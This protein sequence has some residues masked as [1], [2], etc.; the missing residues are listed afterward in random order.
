MTL[1]G[2]LL[3]VGIAA[4]VGTAQLS[5]PLIRL[6]GALKRIAAGDLG[7][8]LE[9][10]RSN[11]EIAQIWDTVRQFVVS[12]REA[13]TLKGQKAELE[14][15]AMAE[16][17]ATMEALAQRFEAEVM[18][19]VRSVAAAAQQLQGNATQMNA[20]AEQTSHRST[21]VAAASEQTTSNVSTVA[22]AAEEL[23]ASVREIGFQVDSSST[24]A[25]EASGKAK[26]AAEAAQGLSINANRIGE[27]VSLISDIAA[28]TNLLALNATIE[29]ARA[30]EAGRGFAVVAQEVKGLAEQTSKATGE[31]AEQIQAVQGTTKTVVG[32]IDGIGITIQQINQISTSI[33]TAVEEQGAATTEI[34][35][36]VSQ[37]A[38]GTREVSANIADVSEAASL[39]S[40]GSTEI[41]A[42]S[43]ELAR[44][45]V[46]LRQQVDSFIAKV[47]AA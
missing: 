44:Q 5:R 6:T 14:E 22:S 1:L 7:I 39:T 23:S 21:I 45:A 9:T 10:R 35:R 11:D 26:A 40:R 3:G 33:A 47:R 2:V 12:L 43:N 24:I 38:Q 34:A 20:T 19:V 4:Y 16:K 31:I 37:A 27:V 36:N 46:A 32:A 25:R 29:A 18:G 17:R 41:V 30:G 28:Q 15:R 8:A 13:E 42:A